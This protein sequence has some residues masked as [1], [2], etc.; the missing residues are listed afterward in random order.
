MND[1]SSYGTV[2]NNA[3]IEREGSVSGT[4]E[5]SFTPQLTGVGADHQEAREIQ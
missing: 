5:G 1:T 2:R 4:D 3:T